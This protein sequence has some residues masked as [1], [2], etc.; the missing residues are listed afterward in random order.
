MTIGSTRPSSLLFRPE[1]P[2]S[3]LQ[4]DDA[5]G[6]LP[7]GYAP[8]VGA[9]YVTDVDAAHAEAPPPPPQPPPPQSAWS[10][11][12]TALERVFPPPVVGALLGMI[13]ALL[14]SVRGILVDLKDRDG[15]AP[16]EWLY[17]GLSKIGAAA[18]PVNMIILGN[19]LAKQLE[20]R[21]RA[22][23]NAPISARAHFSIAFAKLVVMPAIGA[24]IA[25][26]LRALHI[27]TNTNV[28]LVS[29]VVTCAPTAN[30]LMVMAELAGE[31]IDG[32]ATSMFLQYCVTP[33]QLT[34]WLTIYVKI[35]T[36][37][38]G[39]STTIIPSSAPTTA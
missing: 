23:S 27:T 21:N 26:A 16:L 28:L 3:R 17:N 31:N 10:A 35:A 20:P 13:V 7:L 14:P 11:V 30:N 19:S 32:L 9:A 24:G 34:F 25:L 29:M 8:L 22:S 18:V 4:T 1:V 15:N 38:D 2:I 37:G 6:A 33:V 12:L 36:A 39:S 5:R